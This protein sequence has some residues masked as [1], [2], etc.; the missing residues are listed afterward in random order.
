MFDGVLFLLVDAAA[1]DADGVDEE[2]REGR[3]HFHLRA[4]LV[5][6]LWEGFRFRYGGWRLTAD[7]LKD[8]AR[9]VEAL[10]KLGWEK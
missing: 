8:V 10:F 4:G 7:A 5:A 2:V 6:C 1:L 9:D 3:G